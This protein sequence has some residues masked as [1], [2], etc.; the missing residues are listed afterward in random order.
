MDLRVSSDKSRSGIGVT[1][2]SEWDRAGSERPVAELALGQVNV[3]TELEAHLE[4]KRNFKEVSWLK[5][6]NHL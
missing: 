6:R 5:D 3:L 2:L 1:A 4:G